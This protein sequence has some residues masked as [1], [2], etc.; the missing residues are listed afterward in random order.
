[1]GAKDTARGAWVLS[2]INEKESL[3]RK[4]SLGR[5]EMGHQDQLA[6]A[7]RC[8]LHQETEQALPQFI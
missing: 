7:A 2:R 5:T 1:M 3:K 6:A 4:V 8:E